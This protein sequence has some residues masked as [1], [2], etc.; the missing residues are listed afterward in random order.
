[1]YEKTAKIGNL[2]HRLFTIAS[3]ALA[4]FLFFR[5]GY[6]NMCTIRQVLFF[7]WIAYGCF[8]TVKILGDAVSGRHLRENNFKAMLARWEEET[9]ARAAALRNFWAITL[10]TGALKL[11]IPVVLY[12]V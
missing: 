2:L 1:M 9:G 12:V 4:L 10:I 8:A 6:S 3:L 5:Y 7:L 11:V